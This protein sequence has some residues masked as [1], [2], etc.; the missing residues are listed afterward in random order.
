M[1]GLLTLTIS[2]VLLPLMYAVLFLIYGKNFKNP[3]NQSRR[4]FKA[5]FEIVI[6]V[7]SDIAMLCWWRM[8]SPEGAI[9]ADFLF[10]FFIL[11][12]MTFFC[13]TDLLE[14]VIPNRI[15]LV[16]LVIYAVIFIFSFAAEPD[17]FRMRVFNTA[18]GIVFSLITFGVAYL[19]SKKGMGAGD[20]KLALLMGLYLTGERVVPAVL[21]GS[22]IAAVFVIIQLIRKKFT[23]KDNIPF[24]PFLYIGV[25]IQ[26]LLR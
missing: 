14:R 24:V 11:A 16:F 20:V 12:A 25:I 19:I 2:L 13:S 18:L 8:H 15:L 5:W 10:T 21:Y 7:L 23:K 1:L 6:A 9:N 22:I 4:P 3:E 17:S 26:Y